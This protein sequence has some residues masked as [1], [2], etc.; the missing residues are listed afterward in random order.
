MELNLKQIPLSLE[1]EE[2][3]ATKFTALWKY[4]RSS[5]ITGNLDFSTTVYLPRQWVCTSLPR[6]R[7]LFAT[8][9]YR[10]YIYSI[11]P[12]DFY[13]LPILTHH[14][15]GRDSIGTFW[16]RETVSAKYTS[17]VK[18]GAEFKNESARIGEL[19]SCLRS[20]H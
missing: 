7:C 15:L 14:F 9:R 17:M 1:K 10:T 19:L 11:S 2:L 4:L 20:L 12:N 8:K 5:V 16:W 6:H 3:K 13:I 18:T